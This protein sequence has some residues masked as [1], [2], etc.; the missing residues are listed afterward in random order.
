MHISERVKFGGWW[1]DAGVWYL[2]L[3]PPHPHIFSHD[4]YTSPP[5]R[6]WDFRNGILHPELWTFWFVGGWGSRFARFFVDGG[7]EEYG[8]WVRLGGFGG[9]WNLEVRGG[10]GGSGM[11]GLGMREGEIVFVEFSG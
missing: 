7:R 8:G 4:F 1:V 2:H 10:D 3:P 9:M 5:L 6:A 11:G